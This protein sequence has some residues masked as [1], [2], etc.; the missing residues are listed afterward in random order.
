L[1][2]L[3]LIK[4]FHT[5]SQKTGFYQ[6]REQFNFLFTGHVPEYANFNDQGDFLESYPEVCEKIED[7]WPSDDALRYIEKCLVREIGATQAVSFDLEAYRELLMLHGVVKRIVSES[8]S[9]LMPFS[10]IKSSVA[11]AAAPVAVAQ[12]NASIPAPI[13]TGVSIDFDL[14]EP[15]PVNNLMEFDSESFAKATV[16]KSPSVR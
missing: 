12:P 9:D 1:V 3:D 8:D 5:L 6:Y 11:S 15:E 14:S 4:V 16:K 2:Y 7:L 10:A 13:S